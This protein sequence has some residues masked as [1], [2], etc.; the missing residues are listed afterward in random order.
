M[1]PVVDFHMPLMFEA[2]PK[3]FFLILRAFQK[4]KVRLPEGSPYDT[5]FKFQTETACMCQSL[6]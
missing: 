2:F 4:Y 5:S 6:A 1:S 3:L